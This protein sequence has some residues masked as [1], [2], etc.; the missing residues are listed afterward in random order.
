MGVMSALDRVMHN[1][2]PLNVVDDI[3]RP[4]GDNPV[5][6]RGAVTTTVDALMNWA[7]TGSMWPELRAW[8]WIVTVSCSAPVR[9]SPT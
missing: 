6:Q 3:L 2:P 1:P 8:T 7:R 4:A 9:A 5:I